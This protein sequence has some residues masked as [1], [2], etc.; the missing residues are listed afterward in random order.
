PEDEPDRSAEISEEQAP[1][2]GFVQPRDLP[3]LHTPYDGDITGYDV[4]FDKPAA[5]KPKPRRRRRELEE[6]AV[7]MQ[8]DEVA[9]RAIEKEKEISRQ[10]AAAIVPDKIEMDRLERKRERIPKRSP[11]A[12]L[13]FFLFQPQVAVNAV[14]L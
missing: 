6:E 3:A 12:G 10:R 7:P 9:D 11:L 5:E 4:T 1:H 8:R 13:A 2:P 14:V